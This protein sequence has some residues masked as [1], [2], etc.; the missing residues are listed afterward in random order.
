MI[1]VALLNVLADKCRRGL[2]TLTTKSG[3][4]FKDFPTGSCGPA[5]EL[6]GR[7]LKEEAGYDGVY[8]CGSGH[9][10]LRPSQT[11]AWYEIEGYVIDITHDQFDDSGLSGWVF[12]G[13]TSW[14][15]EFLDMDQRDGFCM[16]SG[17]PCYPYDGYSAIKSALAA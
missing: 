16:P 8:V 6:V 9:A 10:R 4:M 5:A 12:A 7:L 11:H 13:R 3:S 1:D 14:H 17:W 2:L 15:A